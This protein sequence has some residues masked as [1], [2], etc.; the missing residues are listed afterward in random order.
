MSDIPNRLDLIEHILDITPDSHRCLHVIPCE[1]CENEICPMRD[2]RVT[3]LGSILVTLLEELRWN[4]LFV[5]EML[6]SGF[7][8]IDACK[9]IET[10]MRIMRLEDKMVGPLSQNQIETVKSEIAKLHTE[11]QDV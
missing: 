3:K 8:S 7:L 5:S 2:N 1:E 10:R 9:R 11:L 4:Q 6:K